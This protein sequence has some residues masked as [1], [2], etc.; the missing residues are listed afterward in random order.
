METLSHARDRS[1]F[2]KWVDHA[3][4]G[5][6]INVPA[7]TYLLRVLI[8]KPRWVYLMLIQCPTEECRKAFVKIL[9]VLMIVCLEGGLNK[10][11]TFSG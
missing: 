4:L 10:G 5:L 7:S 3:V 1:A 2:T 11:M 9:M 6:Q 8:E